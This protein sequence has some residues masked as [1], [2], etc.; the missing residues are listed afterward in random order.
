MIAQKVDLADK[1]PEQQTLQELIVLKIGVI[2]SQKHDIMGKGI[3]AQETEIPVSAN[4]ED[5]RNTMR[6]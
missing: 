1:I 3:A 6:V 4:E 2:R 5:R